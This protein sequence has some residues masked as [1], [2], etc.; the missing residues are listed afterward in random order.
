MYAVSRTLYDGSAPILYPGGP[1]TLQQVV[2]GAGGGAR[3]RLAATLRT[4]VIR[5]HSLPL[6]CPPLALLACPALR[7]FT[8]SGQLLMLAPA[9]RNVSHVLELH[10]KMSQKSVP[11]GV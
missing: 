2:G 3:T 4:L 9:G 10:A 7:S 8:M 6:L 1:V 11:V 5:G